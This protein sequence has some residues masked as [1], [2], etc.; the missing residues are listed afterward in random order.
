MSFLKIDE[1]YRGSDRLRLIEMVKNLS[2]EDYAKFCGAAAEAGMFDIVIYPHSSDMIIAI[3]NGTGLFREEY[4]KKL[5][6]N[7][8]K[9]PDDPFDGL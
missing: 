5:V 9:N 4:C 2:D 3:E 8:I 6:E 7:I 1:Y